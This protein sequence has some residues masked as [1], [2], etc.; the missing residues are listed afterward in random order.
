MLNYGDGVDDAFGQ[1]LRGA[2]PI[3]RKASSEL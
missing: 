2:A 3:E 1:R